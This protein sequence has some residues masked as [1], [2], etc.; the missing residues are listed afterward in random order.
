MP[1]CRIIAIIGTAGRDASKPITAAQWSAMCADLKLFSCLEMRF[2]KTTD[3][4]HN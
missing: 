4:H 2:N 3:R 1:A